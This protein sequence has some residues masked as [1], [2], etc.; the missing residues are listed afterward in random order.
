MIMKG[1]ILEKNY[2]KNQIFDIFGKEM[3]IQSILR[4]EDSVK[5][6]VTEIISLF[7]EKY[8]EQKNPYQYID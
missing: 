3:L 4:V 8:F 6:V 5:I 2:L 7:L 1:L